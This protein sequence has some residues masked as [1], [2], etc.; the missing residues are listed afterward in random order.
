MRLNPSEELL[1]AN[2]PVGAWG[3]E[4]SSIIAKLA[5]D[6]DINI[7]A[8][9]PSKLYNQQGWLGREECAFCHFAP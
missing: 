1:A 9:S 5:P 3:W 2:Y 4:L 8:V 6:C 7:E